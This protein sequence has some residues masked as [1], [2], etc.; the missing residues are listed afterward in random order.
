MMKRATQKFSAIRSGKLREPVLRLLAWARAYKLSSVSGNW[1]IGN[2]SDPATRLGQ[3]P[4]RSSSV[5]NFF[6]PGY[7]P[8]NSAI[9]A[10]S[11][12]APEFQITNESTVVGYVNYMQRW[13]VLVIRI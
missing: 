12:V 2:T 3:S 7:L 5:F 11:L 9:A 1:S 10:A 4:S 6:R 8:P 13:S